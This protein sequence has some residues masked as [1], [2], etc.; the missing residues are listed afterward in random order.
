MISNRVRQ[1]EVQMVIASLTTATDEKKMEPGG[2]SGSRPTH[3]G[4]IRS[5]TGFRKSC[6]RKRGPFPGWPGGY[7]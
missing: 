7:L 4:E 1:E 3:A 2:F 5:A 6:K